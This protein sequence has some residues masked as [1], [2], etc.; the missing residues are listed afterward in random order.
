MVSAKAAKVRNYYIWRKPAQHDLRE[1]SPIPVVQCFVPQLTNSL[2]AFMGSALTVLD[3]GLALNHCSSPVKGLMP[4]LF[5]WAGFFLSFKL[6]KL[7]I[8]KVS[9]IF[10]CSPAKLM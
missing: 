1:D 4:F 7:P 6:R 5:F 3:A 10:S 9:L 2:R 8:L